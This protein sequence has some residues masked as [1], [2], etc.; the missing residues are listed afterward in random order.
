MGQRYWPAKHVISR[1]AYRAAV[2]S[3]LDNGF[4]ALAALSC[5]SWR[6]PEDEQE[7][8]AMA[9]IARRSGLFGPYWSWDDIRKGLR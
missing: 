8:Q 6:I 7:R 3:V 5:Q 9:R 2:A 4:D 1:D